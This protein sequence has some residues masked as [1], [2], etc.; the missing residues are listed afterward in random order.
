MALQGIFFQSTS[1]FRR[2]YPR[3]SGLSSTSARIT[4]AALGLAVTAW[5]QA[6]V[7]CDLNIKSTPGA[8]AETACLDLVAL[9][10]GG[11]P[12]KTANNATRISTDG[13]RMCKNAFQVG[14]PAGADV[15]FI[16]D[17]SG[18]MYSTFARINAATGDTA[19]YHNSGC[20]SQNPPTTGTMTYNT[21][22]G[23]RTVRLVDSTVNCTQHAGDPYLARGRVITQGIDF[24]AQTSPNSTA[25]AIAFSGDISHLQPPLL[26]ATPGNPD[27]VKASVMPESVSSTIY[28][29]PLQRAHQWLDDTAITNTSKRAIVFVSDGE[30]NDASQLNNFL[31]NPN[32]ADIPIYTIAL[33]DSGVTFTRMQDMSTRTG[34]RFF[35]VAPDNIAQMNLVMQ[36]II[37]AITV[38]TL[39]TAIEVTNSSFAPPMVSRSTGMTRNPDS[40][41]SLVLDSIIALKLGPNNL[42]IKI[43]MSPTDIRTFPVTVQADG[44]AAGGSTSD[45]VCHAMPTLVMLNQSGAVDTAYPSGPTQ[46]DVRLIRATSDLEQVVVTAISRDSARGAGWGDAESITLPQT[47]DAGGLTTNR[48]ENYN[49]N[50]GSASPAKG[51]NTLEA[52]PNGEVVLTWTHPRDPRE[53]ATFILPGRKIPVTPGFI[54]IVRVTDVP[55][56]VTINVPVNNPIVIRGGVAI[57]QAGDGATITHKG[58]LF[59]PHNIS[60]A[61]LNPNQTP[62]FVFKTAS[63]FSYQVSI[64]DH[65]G[66]F[67]NAQEGKVDSARWEQMR[68]NADSL[69]VAFSILP[70]SEEGQQFGTG[71]YIMRATLTTLD[72]T[73]QD[74]GQPKRV[75]PITRVLVN[76]FGYRR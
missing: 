70:V 10:S 6:P 54:D 73:R 48:R 53:T 52:A 68:G 75:T 31:N 62:T 28:V 35:R 46:Y 14:L 24:L 19:F 16:Y 17:N 37:Q 49:F 29:T 22:M 4:L 66:Q 42:S 3:L 36:Q 74:P 43:T 63:P 39:P 69:A 21:L 44:P 27:I 1:A 65:L 67:L 11:A 15:V 38:V 76:R 41:V 50:G 71:V 56:G 13:F 51:N 45:L 40:S 61:T 47:G 59:N 9:Q 12:V 25:G 18:S 5:A 72:A 20:G 57:G 33:G 2:F 8:G 26:L 64:F 7:R 60:D 30:P 34:G 58:V 32:N 55:K 23:P